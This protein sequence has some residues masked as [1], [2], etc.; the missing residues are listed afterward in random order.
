M[1]RLERLCGADLGNRL[2]ASWSKVAFLVSDGFFFS[3]DVFSCVLES[4]GGRSSWEPLASGILWRP[5]AG[6]PLRIHFRLCQGEAGT[7]DVS[8]KKEAI[9]QEG[10]RRYNSKIRK[11]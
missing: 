2:G 3:V 9:G 10:T 4:D 7:L 8:D 11:F 6:I 1:L 5:A